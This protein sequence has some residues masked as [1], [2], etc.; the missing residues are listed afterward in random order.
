MPSPHPDHRYR[1][2]S[3]AARVII[4]AAINLLSAGS[5]WC[6]SDAARQIIQLAERIDREIESQNADRLPR[7]T[8]SDAGYLRRVTLD[9]AGRIPT[10][11]E[12]KQYEDLDLPDKRL[13]VTTSLIQSPDFA[14]H[15]RNELDTFLLRPLNHDREWRSYLLEATKENR[16]WD[17]VFREI[18]TPEETRPEDLRPTAFLKHRL[19]DLDKLANDS[20]VIW[21]GVNIGCAKCHDHPL[22]DD[23]KQ[24]HYYGISSFFKRTYRSKK[25][26]IGER[27][28]GKVKFDTTSGE[29]KDADFMFLTGTKVTEPELSLDAEVLKQYQE[30][31]KKAEQDDAAETPPQ[32]LFRPRQQLVDLALSDQQQRFFAKNIVNRTWARFFGRGIVHPLDQIHSGNPA[33]HPTLLAILTDDFI[34]SGYNVQRLIH[35]ITLSVAYAQ[36]LPITESD[37]PSHGENKLE[38]QSDRGIRYFQHAE[39]RPLSPHQLSLSLLIATGNPEKTAEQI[40]NP[41]WEQ[42]RGKLEERSE[43][44]AQKLEIP[45][46]NFQ[47]PVSEALWFSN[48][49]EMQNQYLGGGKDHLVGY[50][51]E[52]EDPSAI[53]SQ[54]MLATLGREATSEEQVVLSKYFEQRNEQRVDT[55]KNIVW[56]LVCSPEFRFNH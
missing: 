14:Y 37:S 47:V 56:A 25:G 30:Q 53:I 50:L 2:P 27:F 38:N 40:S 6:D 41:D 48:S 35:A 17:S 28:D 31:I 43:G 32:P 9:L 3:L 8:L 16:P 23:W 5:A 54:A 20:S 33:S 42:D 18:M 29:S 15:Q 44:L 12:I 11:A 7:Q 36:A 22:V 55:I 45:G 52:I 10:I 39:P 19:G 13:Q 46:E 4:I 21:F 1:S 49:S 24:E 26:L 34:N 51:N